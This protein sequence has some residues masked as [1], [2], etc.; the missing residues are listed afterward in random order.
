MVERLERLAVMPKVAG[1][2]LAQARDSKTLT[3]HLAA[4]GYL[5]NLVKVKYEERRCLGHVFHMPCP[6]H[7]RAL[8]PHCPDG[9]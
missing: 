9:H 8:T 5:I 1:S 3:V 7:D 4:N 2:R 6:R